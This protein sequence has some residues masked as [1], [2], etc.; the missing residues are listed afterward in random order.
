M[1]LSSAVL[2][3]HPVSTAST[4]D[5]ATAPSRRP[6]TRSYLSGYARRGRAPRFRIR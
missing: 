6:R 3:F 4:A 5:R 1:Q 2:A